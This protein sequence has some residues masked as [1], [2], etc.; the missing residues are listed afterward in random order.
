M[1]F[2]KQ[3]TGKAEV[4]RKK[5]KNAFSHRQMQDDDIIL[6][7]SYKENTGWQSVLNILAGLV[8]GAVVIFFLV[9][10]ASKEAL[11][12]RHNEELRQN[13]EIINQKSIEIDSLNQKLEAAKRAEEQAENALTTMQNDSGSILG[14]Y[15]KLVQILEAYRN[16]DSAGAALL[17]V[18]LDASVLQDGVLNDIVAWVQQDMEENGW[19]LL[20]QM[21]DEAMAQENGVQQAVEAY[22]KSLLIR[23][24]DPELLYKLAMAYLVSGDADTAN[25]YFGE[26]IMNHPDSE[27]AAPAKEQRG[28]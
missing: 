10:P 6:P 7:P 25:Q 16:G 15:Q 12:A 13:L 23:K 27:Y 28:F 18:E 9:M 26:V 1:A 24:D 21:G 4:E 5:I 17:Y 11:N 20:M 19:Q 2:V 3:N 8:L 22:Q 14:Q